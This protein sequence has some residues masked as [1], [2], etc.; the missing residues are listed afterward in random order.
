MVLTS[1][2]RLKLDIWSEI[3]DEAKTIDDIMRVVWAKET[4]CRQ[5]VNGTKTIALSPSSQ[6]AR[7]VSPLISY[8]ITVIL[9]IWA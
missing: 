1:K 2:R 6:E 7:H 4:H 9:L 8:H 5:N 3:T